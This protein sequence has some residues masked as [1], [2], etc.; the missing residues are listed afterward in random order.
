MCCFITKY[1]G[2]LEGTVYYTAQTKQNMATVEK[3][4]HFVGRLLGWYDDLFPPPSQNN[5]HK[6][7]LPDNG[8]DM[9]ILVVSHGGPIKLLMPALVK[10]RNVQ[11]SR[12]AQDRADAMDHKVWNCSITEVVMQQSAKPNAPWTGLITK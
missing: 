4:E 2:K 7:V 11:W 1:L 6:S 12:E 3:P 8:E 5:G 10:E 9:T